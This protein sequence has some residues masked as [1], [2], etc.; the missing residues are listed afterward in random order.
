[1][2]EGRPNRRQRVAMMLTAL[3]ALGVFV[4]LKT[5]WIVPRYALHPF[6]V[7]DKFGRQLGTLS[8]RDLAS[9]QLFFKLKPLGGDYVLAWSVGDPIYVVDCRDVTRPRI[10]ANLLG[11]GDEEEVRLRGGKI[12]CLDNGRVVVGYDLEDPSKPERIDTQ[13]MTSR[14]LT[15]Y[16]RW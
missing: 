10:V 2:K 1:M 12:F 4:W 13:G 5:D 16:P 8:G 11:L 14:D 3:M 7:Q 6:R 9:G 15:F